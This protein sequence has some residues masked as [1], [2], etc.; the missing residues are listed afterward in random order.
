MPWNLQQ[1]RLVIM[2]RISSLLWYVPIIP[3]Q[4]Q[5]G[6]THPNSIAWSWQC[7]RHFI[8]QQSGLIHENPSRQKPKNNI[9]K[10]TRAN[11]KCKKANSGHRT[12]HICIFQLLGSWCCKHRFHII[13]CVAC[14]FLWLRTMHSSSTKTILPPY[15]C[16]W[17]QLGWAWPSPTQTSTLIYKFNYFFRTS[18]RNGWCSIYNES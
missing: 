12:V 6:C 4:E 7:S 13:Y 2:T 11:R 1:W 18:Y 10:C 3:Y 14:F 8:P 16:N 9:M 17:L 15:W 5:R